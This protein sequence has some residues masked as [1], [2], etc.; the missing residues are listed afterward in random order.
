MTATVNIVDDD[1]AGFTISP[2]TLTTT[3][4]GPNETFT[5]VL[6][7]EPVSNVVISVVSN[8]IAEGTVSPANLTFT[9]ATY[10]LPQTV[11]VDPVDDSIVDGDKTY[12][13]TMGVVD[14]SSDNNFDLLPNQNVSVTNS[15]NDL[16]VLTIGDI[17][18][19]EDIASGNLI[20]NVTLDVQVVGGFTVGYTFANGTAIG[21]GT[22]F[23]GNP[24]TLT[25]TGTAGEVQN[26]TVPINNDQILEQ[27]EN[28]TV[29]LGLP[30]NPAV[31]LA[32]GGTATGSINDDDNCAPA[33]I[34]DTSVATSFCD[35]IDVN[36]NSYTS[37]PP[38]AG[39]V[40]TW[41]TSIR[42]AKR[43]CLFNPCSGS[44]PTQRRFLFWFFLGY[45]RNAYRFFR[46]LR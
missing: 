41:S 15:D 22:D 11:T 9:P 38:P 19:N 27:T 13:I 28:F 17:A 43:K 3:E 14:A 4:N 35:V 46:R 6:S 18:E 2:T 34:L 40:L 29:Q 8:D 32:G 30:S 23:S 12:T 39:T 1:T 16:A 5:V 45:Q 42:S 31:T 44:K 33:P 20:F 7:A 26:I 24:G 21:G 36:L 10:N 25:F 37:T